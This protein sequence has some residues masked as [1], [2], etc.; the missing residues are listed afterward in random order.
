MTLIAQWVWHAGDPAPRNLHLQFRR[1]FDLPA[2]PG[3]ATLHLSADSRYLLYVNGVR[4]GYGPARAY[5]ENYEYDSYDLTAHLTVG[6]NL[7]AVDV[8]HYGEATFQ[9]RVGRGGLI[10]QLDVDGQPRLWTDSAWRTKPSAALIQHTPRAAIQLPWEEQVDARLED[11]GWTT[12]GFD[13]TAW[14][15][16]LV[17]GPLVLGPCCSGPKGQGLRSRQ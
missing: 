4:L 17:I 10:A 6:R 13:D 3:A 14:E 11:V 12:A 2:R 16:A 7:I 9:H 8:S 5:Q 1:A 15:P